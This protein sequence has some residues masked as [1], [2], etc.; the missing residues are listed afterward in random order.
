GP[1]CFRENELEHAKEFTDVRTRDDERRKQAQCEVMR[2]VDQQATPKGFD[3]EGIAIHGKLNSDHQAFT[4]NLTDKVE[5]LGEGLQAFAQL[6]AARADI[7][8]QLFVLDD[9]ENF[10]RCGTYE[11]STSKC[12]A[13]Q[14]WRNVAGD[15]FAG[16]NGTERQTR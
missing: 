11:R 10:E 4:T 12:G 16:E 8:E 9:P 1:G 13:V 7:L 3:D 15:G 5:A 14:T 2:A 6:S